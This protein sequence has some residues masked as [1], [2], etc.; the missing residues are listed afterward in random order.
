M[1][2]VCNAITFQSQMWR[3]IKLRK[4]QALKQK[5]RS[6]SNKQPFETN[7]Y[8]KMCGFPPSPSAFYWRLIKKMIRLWKVQMR[9][10]RGVTTKGEEGNDTPN[11][12]IPKALIDVRL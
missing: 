9:R 1:L 6:K 12:M 8:L 11:L 3:L 4:G 7:I 5:K 10:G 2:R